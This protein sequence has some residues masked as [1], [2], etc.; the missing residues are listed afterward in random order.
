MSA[1]NQRI[2]SVKCSSIRECQ[3][4]NTPPRYAMDGGRWTG[5]FSG[6]YG[7]YGRCVRC[8]CAGRS[9]STAQQRRVST[10][11]CRSRC[12][13]CVREPT[14]RPNKSSSPRLREECKEKSE[15]SQVSTRTE[16][17]GREDSYVR[18]LRRLI[19]HVPRQAATRLLR[20]VAFPDVAVK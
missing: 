20:P 6:M 19:K 12:L 11:L 15:M 16:K 17:E 4:T 5:C 7:I 10:S 18:L 3:I 14:D 2:K 1:M 13:A 9:P 8:G